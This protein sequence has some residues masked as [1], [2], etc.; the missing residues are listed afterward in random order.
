MTTP[1][2][3]IAEG[4]AAKFLTALLAISKDEI[5]GPRVVPDGLFLKTLPAETLAAALAENA[6][7]R[8][9]VMAVVYQ[10][11]GGGNAVYPRVFYDTLTPDVMAAQITVCVEA[12]GADAVSGFIRD[13][14]TCK[15]A[16]G[17]FGK[18]GLWRFICANGLFA[19]SPDA[20]LGAMNEIDALQIFTADEKLARIGGA[21]ILEALLAKDCASLLKT[22][23]ESALTMGV[24]ERQPFTATEFFTVVTNE[25]LVQHMGPA[26]LFELY[27]IVAAQKVGIF[28]NDLA[29]NGVTAEAPKAPERE[30]PPAGSELPPPIPDL[31]A[32][33]AA[34]PPTDPDPDP[35]TEIDVT[36]EE[37]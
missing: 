31:S 28:V 20:V 4:L 5:H 30:A 17:T 10:L 29:H 14:I 21:R 33:P 27:V 15:Q 22:V 26:Q 25:E 13:A 2:I 3:P 23:A 32:A 36:V 18:F 6:E 16:V 34:A 7:S 24:K 37:T 35:G 8:A 19:A 12:N 1:N 11:L 9:E